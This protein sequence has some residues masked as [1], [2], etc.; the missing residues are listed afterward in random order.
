MERITPPLFRGYHHLTLYLDDLEEIEDIL[1]GSDG[2][3]F[4]S[5]EYKFENIAELSEQYKDQQLRSIRIFS[6]D[7]YVEIVLEK[8][9]NILHCNTSDPTKGSGI[10]HRLDNVLTRASRK[11]RVLYPDFWHINIMGSVIIVI[12]IASIAN[13]LLWDTAA[14]FPPFVKFGLDSNVRISIN[15]ILASLVWWSLLT[16]RVKII[17]SRRSQRRNF[18]VRNRDQ[19][20]T[21]LIVAAASVT[22]ALI[23]S[24]FFQSTPKP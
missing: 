10:F 16:R 8:S 7:P 9:V 22:L 18:F 21:N 2:L 4:R 14:Y 11:P 5:I 1:K 15:L 24:H 6:F 17:I 20:I 12:F 19:L 13:L 23:A 3:N